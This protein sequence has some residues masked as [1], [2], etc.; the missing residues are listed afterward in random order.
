MSEYLKGLFDVTLLIIF[1]QIWSLGQFRRKERL[2]E[3]S[4]WSFLAAKGAALGSAIWV[5]LS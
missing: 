3:W 5:C 4:G 2:W 1:L